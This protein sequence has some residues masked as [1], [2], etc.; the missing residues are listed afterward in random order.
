MKRMWVF[1]KAKF[2]ESLASYKQKDLAAVLNLTQSTMSRRITRANKRGG[3]WWVD[4]IV[5]LSNAM[6][7]DPRDFFREIP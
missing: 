4:D 1:D 7:L 2:A 6:G 5:E 3:E